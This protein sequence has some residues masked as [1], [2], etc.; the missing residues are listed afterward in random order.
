MSDD[1][2][3]RRATRL[4]RKHKLGPGS[5]RVLNVDDNGKVTGRRTNGKY[6]ERMATVGA[7]IGPARSGLDRA[8]TPALGIGAA[9][10]RALDP[11]QVHSR[12]VSLQEM[13]PEQRAE[14]HR[15]YD[16]SRPDKNERLQRI[17]DAANRMKQ[18][19]SS[20]DVPTADDE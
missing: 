16:R 2:D 15:M 6:R 10:R 1:E 3:P 5:V 8:D 20:P 18:T 7:V 19:G 12:A 11:A 13:A 4:R 9:I 17:R 14:M